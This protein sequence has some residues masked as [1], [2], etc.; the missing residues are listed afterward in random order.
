MPVTKEGLVEI[1]EN[2][3]LLSMQSYPKEK[4]GI[5]SKLQYLQYLSQEPLVV[6]SG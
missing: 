4:L 6:I 3:G 5:S 2:G 1:C